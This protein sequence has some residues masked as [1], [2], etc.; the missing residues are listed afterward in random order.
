MS[1]LAMTVDDADDLRALVRTVLESNDF[2]VIEAASG[3][4]ALDLLA[5]GIHPDVIV[6]DV[7]MPD[8]DGWDTLAA[9]RA[10]ADTAEVA[11]VLCTVRAAQADIDHGWQLGCDG[12]LPKPFAIDELARTVLEVSAR[13]LDERAALR[14]EH[15]TAST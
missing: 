7:Q 6:L 14:A 9:I 13:S 1:G 4:A 15:Q 10:Q 2:V 12:F 8:L 5:A 3:R 11:V